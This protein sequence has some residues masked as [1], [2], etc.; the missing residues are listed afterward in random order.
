MILKVK[1]TEDLL[2][3]CWFEP[4]GDLP[5]LGWICESPHFGED[6]LDQVIALLDQYMEAARWPVWTLDG[7]WATVQI[8]SD[9]TVRLPIRQTK[10]PDIFAIRSQPFEI[11]SNREGFD[12][13]FIMNHPGLDFVTE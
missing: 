12:L 1:P 11:E 7:E 6:N 9:I 3:S 5:E 10:N 8:F 4:R 13:W 2:R